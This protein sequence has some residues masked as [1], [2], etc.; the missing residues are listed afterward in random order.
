[1]NVLSDNEDDSVRSIDRDQSLCLSQ[2]K[3]SGQIETD[4]NHE[5]D[6]QDARSSKSAKWPRSAKRKQPSSHVAGPVQKRK[7]RL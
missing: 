7:R 2:G 6:S 4:R 3:S 1:V 5:F